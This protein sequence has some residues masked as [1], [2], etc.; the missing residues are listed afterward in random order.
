MTR[1]GIIA[2]GGVLPARLIAACRARGREVFVLA[3]KGHAD[4][5]AWPAEV[6][7]E[8]IALG[9]AGR[10]IGI[11]RRQGVR[12][13]VMVGP[14]KR[15]SMRELAPDWWTVRFFAKVGLRALG[16]NGLLSAVV[17]E[18][19]REGFHVVG[20]DEILGDLLAPA[21]AIGS[22]RP[23]SR[24]Q[25]DIAVGVTAAR[26]HGAA[27]LGQAVVVRD[28]T[29]IDREDVQGTDALIRRAAPAQGAV[30]VKTA[31]PGQE[32]RVDLPTVGP[33][34]IAAAAAAGFAGI[35]VEAGA[36]LIV[37]CKECVTAADAAG[38]F[39]F[40]VS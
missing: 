32:R 25:A 17:A 39:L 20:I 9:E 10:G 16:D 37:D 5:S 36:T 6:P 12:D 8:E 1:L 35:A 3:L 34:T 15:P 27:D 22:H 29:V 19:E 40:G 23:D 2:G 24:A 31:K 4:P 33:A 21:G 28:G 30:F 13:L 7:R 14:V 11:L 26:T 38:L 18:L